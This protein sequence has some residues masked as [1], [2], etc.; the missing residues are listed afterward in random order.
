MDFHHAMAT[1]PSREFYKKFVDIVKKEYESDMIQGILF[2][3]HGLFFKYLCDKF[4]TC[5]SFVNFLEQ[6]ENCWKIVWVVS[7]KSK[8]MRF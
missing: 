5:C 8:S 7:N 6:I 3:T 1:D 4:S 2:I